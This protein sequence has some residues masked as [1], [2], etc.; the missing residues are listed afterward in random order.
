MLYFRSDNAVIVSVCETVN[1]DHLRC[2]LTWR[3]GANYW[4]TKARGVNDPGSLSRSRRKNSLKTGKLR[5]T[6]VTRYVD[7]VLVQF[8]A[9][10]FGQFGPQELHSRLSQDGGPAI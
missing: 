2:K 8:S 6:R 9:G 1:C 5:K 4:E 7:G 3:E 10:L